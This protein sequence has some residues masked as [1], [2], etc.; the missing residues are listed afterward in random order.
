MAVPGVGKKTAERMVLELSEKVMKFAA[1]PT[2]GRPAAVSGE[3]V[4]SALVNLGYRKGDAERAV[5]SI[6]RVG[7]PKDFGEFL[8]HALK[9]LTGG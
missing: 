3:D 1:E 2:V 6:G 4:V 9:K 5:D 8:K 7:A